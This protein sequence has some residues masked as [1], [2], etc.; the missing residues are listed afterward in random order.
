MDTVWIIAWLSSL[1]ALCLILGIVCVL[2]RLQMERNRF[3]LM[4]L[5]AR[6]NAV[7]DRGDPVRIK[8]NLKAQPPRKLGFD[9]TA[10]DNEVLGDIL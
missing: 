5:R 9:L 8:L 6:L 2:F 7:T 3:E 1:S 4:K 10:L